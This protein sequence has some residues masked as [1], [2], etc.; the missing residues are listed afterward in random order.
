M[1]RVQTI[2]GIMYAVLAVVAAGTFFLKEGI[3][4]ILNF[5]TSLL[6]WPFSASG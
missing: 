4:F 1:G 5:G 3:L 6:W 2:F